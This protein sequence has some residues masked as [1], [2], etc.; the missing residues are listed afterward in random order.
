[1]IYFKE[2]SNIKSDTIDERIK[3]EKLKN[4]NRSE[5]AKTTALSS[6]NIDNYKYLTGEEILFAK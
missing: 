6:G 1:M 4:D 5:I 2:C 3:D